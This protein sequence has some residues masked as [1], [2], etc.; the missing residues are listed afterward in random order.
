MK[1][2]ELLA[3]VE[4]LACTADLDLEVPGV[5]YDSRLVQPGDVFVAITGYSVDGHA[6]I[7]AALEKGAAAVICERPQD[8]PYVQ[9]ASSRLALALAAGNWFGHPSREMTMIGVTG[10]NG[11]TSTTYLLK[12][13]LEQ[14]QGAKVGLVGTIQNMIGDTVLPTERTTPESWE[15]Q[16]LFRQMADAGCR[17]AIMEVSSHALALHRVAGIRFHT[18]IFTNLTQDHLDFHETMA[19]YLEAKA[20]LFAQ[21]DHGVINL[22]DDA[23][24]PRLLAAPQCPMLTYGQR[25]GAD[26]RAEDCQLGRDHVAM[27]VRYDGQ[28]CPVRVG[29][30]GSF[31]VHNALGVIG[32]AVTLG[33]SLE[34]IADALSRAKG[35]KGRVEVVPTPGKDYTILIDYAHTPDGLENVLSTVKGFAKGRTVAVFGCGGDRD[36]TKRPIMGGIAA[37]LA[38]FVVVTSDNPR[39]ED[40]EA[41][42]QEI[43]AG[44]TGTETPYTVI[45]DRRAAIRWAMDNARPEDVIVLAGKGHED[46]QILGTTKVHLDEREVVQ[47]HLDG[48]E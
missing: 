27:T 32:A 44:M 30:P 41:I 14:A 20:L 40:P 13:V 48:L 8:C 2:R 17:Y 11:K 34:A 5:R 3:G 10:T 42:I 22:D 7:P 18:A 35:V 16:A 47:A 26:L 15:L 31:T 25:E 29:I 1:L 23:S 21:C 33:L 38:D 19:A 9:V 45:S 4:I 43:L 12:S 36:R 39:T 24:A 6:F 37:R 46:Y 28:A